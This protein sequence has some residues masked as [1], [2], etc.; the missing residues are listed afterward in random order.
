MPGIFHTVS[1]PLRRYAGQKLSW[2]IQSS[3]DIRTLYLDCATWLADAGTLIQSVAYLADASI[4]VLGYGHDDKTVWWTVR[5]GTPGSY[6][7]IATRLSLADGNREN[8]NVIIPVVKQFPYVPDDAIAN[9][10]QV[11]TYNS[12][13]IEVTSMPGIPGGPADQDLLVLFRAPNIIGTLPIGSLPSSGGSASLRLI[14]ADNVFGHRTL[15]FDQAGHVLHA[16]PMLP[17][18][19]FAGISTQAANAG[20]SV[21]VAMSGVVVEPSWDWLSDEPLF[22]GLDG[23]LTQ[24]P[25]IN[26]VMQQIAVAINAT[27]ILVQPY[28]PITLH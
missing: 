10:G 28:A 9:G 8:V 12:R 24:A 26:G 5:G 7:V 14:T 27:S 17:K 11:V 1:L 2:P 16:N 13:P 21:A 3:N 18:F 19:A 4:E 22:V 25:P 23:L 6:P 15:M 20:D